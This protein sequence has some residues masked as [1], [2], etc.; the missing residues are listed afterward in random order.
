MN[1]ALINILQ[2]ED[3]GKNDRRVAA[4]LVSV[5]VPLTVATALG[6]VKLSR[7]AWAAVRAARKA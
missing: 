6:V 5:A 3:L 2:G 4:A 7:S 1:G